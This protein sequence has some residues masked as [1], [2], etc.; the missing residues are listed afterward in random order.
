MQKSI[1]NNIYDE[2]IKTFNSV[3]KIENKT[4]YYKLRSEYHFE[5]FLKISIINNKNCLFEI[6]D[7]LTETKEINQ[8]CLEVKIIV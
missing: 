7:Y 5:I 3:F 2:E 6:I 1:I 8:V 4:T